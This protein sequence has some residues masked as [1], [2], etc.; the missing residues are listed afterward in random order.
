MEWRSVPQSI[1]PRRGVVVDDEGQ[2]LE[3]WYVCL[4]EGGDSPAD[5]HARDMELFTRGA[6]TRLDG[7]FELDKVPASDFALSIRG[8]RYGGEDG[9]ALVLT[10]LVAPMP[11]LVLRVP[12]PPR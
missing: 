12:R 1:R 5:Y 4:L 9:P 8:P 11:S 2:P 6:T 3:D 7:N 10:D